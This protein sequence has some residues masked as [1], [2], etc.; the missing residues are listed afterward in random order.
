M[1]YPSWNLKL[2]CW[3][4]SYILIMGFCWLQRGLSS[5]VSARYQ[6]AQLTGNTWNWSKTSAC[7]NYTFQTRWIYGS[8]QW[9]CSHTPCGL[10][11]KSRGLL[12]NCDW[13]NFCRVIT[14]SIFNRS[15]YDFEWCFQL[16][17]K[18]YTINIIMIDKSM[19]ELWP[20]KVRRVSYSSVSCIRDQRLLYETKFE[21]KMAIS[22]R[23][24][25]SRLEG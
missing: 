5:S 19:T 14:L 10:Q 24:W 8:S 12:E 21:R 11:C 13:V 15:W 22:D 23:P 3:Q 25:L 18:R 9:N 1:Q 17:F 16:A 20:F 6:Q 4:N 2:P 7:N